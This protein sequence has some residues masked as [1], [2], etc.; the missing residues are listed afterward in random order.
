MYSTRPKQQEI[1][2]KDTYLN[3][4]VVILLI[5]VVII[6]M[7]NPP[8]EEANAEPPGNLT[9]HIVW[10]VGNTDVDLWV[11]GPGEPR[12]IGYSRKS[13]KL[14]DLLRDDLGLIPDATGINFENAFTRG[15]VA[16]AYTVN[17]MCYRCPS[18][19]QVVN[20][21]VALSPDTG[22]LKVLVTTSVTLTKQGQELTAIRFYLEADGTIR[23]GSL[24]RVFKPL[25]SAKP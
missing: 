4:L 21:E 10:P 2:A 11:H 16:G 7:L 3:L 8:T 17:V 22:P 6:R 13:G 5:L 14:W 20:V 12:A 23:P 18:V 15:I 25:R 24:H 19:P 1:T 9:V